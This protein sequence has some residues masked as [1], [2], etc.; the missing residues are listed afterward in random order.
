[1]AFFLLKKFMVRSFFVYIEYQA[2]RFAEMVHLRRMPC[3][4]N[5]HP[6]TANPMVLSHGSLS[7]QSL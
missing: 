6:V 5:A 2:I 7:F 4:V 1:M 3:R